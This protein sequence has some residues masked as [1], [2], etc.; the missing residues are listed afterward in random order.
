MRCSP[1][2]I[3]RERVRPSLVRIWRWRI[4]PG[5]LR[6]PT[7]PRHYR[8][9]ATLA[10]LTILSGCFRHVPCDVQ[11]G[12]GTVSKT[13]YLVQRGWHTGISI[14]VTDWPRDRSALLDDLPAAKRLEFG[15]GDAVYYQSV[16]KDLSMLLS[17]AF[18][19][20]PSVI[21]VI[22]VEPEQIAGWSAR[23]VIPLRLTSVQLDALVASI[24]DEFATPTQ[25]DWTPQP[26]GIELASA[27]G[28]IR[29]YHAHGSFYFPRTCN[30]WIAE[31]L[32]AAGCDLGSSSIISASALMRRVQKVSDEQRSEVGRANPSASR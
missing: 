28:R 11:A 6:A 23:R 26:T 1:T 25:Q 3:R 8:Q 31:R 10:V 2:S 20:T 29:F 12:A 24:A 13:V 19:P 16:D 4:G 7:G 9:V 15:W 32:E 17:A 5:L 27:S 14:D 22:G 18:L 21:E 30:R